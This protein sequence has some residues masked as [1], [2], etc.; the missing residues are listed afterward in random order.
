MHMVAPRTG[1]PEV[2]VAEEQLEYST[3]TCAEYTMPENHPFAGSR[4]LVS[5][6]RFTD[7]DLAALAGVSVAELAR[8][9]KGRTGDDLYISHLTFDGTLQP[10]APQ[11]GTGGWVAT[12]QEG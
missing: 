11:V 4:Y 8:I 2:T 12:V 5:R 3:L 1:A 10:L 6:W 9:R 7:E